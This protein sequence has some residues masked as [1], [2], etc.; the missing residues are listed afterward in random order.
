MSPWT[1]RKVWGIA[2]PRSQ[3]V[4]GDVLERSTVRKNDRTG[5]LVDGFASGVE[6]ADALLGVFHVEERSL[7][8]STRAGE[9][10]FDRGVQAD[11]HSFRF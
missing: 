7:A 3:H 2:S 6:G 1:P 10:S 11:D 4:R 5:S 9:N 8:I